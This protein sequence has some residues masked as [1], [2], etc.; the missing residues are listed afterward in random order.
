[1]TRLA[2]LVTVPLLALAAAGCNNAEQA[3][4]NPAV[5]AP[6]LPRH[7]APKEKTEYSKEAAMDAKS[8]LNPDEMKKKL[9][10]EQ[11]NVCFNKGTE[12]P[13]T[14]KYWDNHAKGTYKCVA[15]GQELFAS[16]TKFDSGTGWP[17][18]YKPAADKAVA[19][20]RDTS[21]GMT[22]TE[23]TCSNCGAHLGHV[24]DDGPNPTGLRYCINSASLDFT[25]KK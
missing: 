25:E 18:F 6:G 21:Y 1:M 15:C 19:E 14:G 17:S 2:R 9:S 13:F 16:D 23:V 8:P 7:A 22:R 11:Y 3:A 12:R 10:P 5:A 20:H 4:A 24:F